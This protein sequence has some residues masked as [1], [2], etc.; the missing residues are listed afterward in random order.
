MF[1]KSNFTNKQIIIGSSYEFGSSKYNKKDIFIQLGNYF[2]KN[3]KNIPNIRIPNIGWDN[4]D[5]LH[6]DYGRIKFIYETIIEKLL[7]SNEFKS[8]QGF[9]H[10][11]K[12]ELEINIGIWLRSFIVFVYR[13]VKEFEG[14]KKEYICFVEGIE[15]ININ[16]KRPLNMHDYFFA[17]RRRNKLIDNC[18]IDILIILGLVKE[19]NINWKL[20]SESAIKVNEAFKIKKF[21]TLSLKYCKGILLDI[22]L[23]LSKKFFEPV[24]YIVCDIDIFRRIKFNLKKVNKL[25]YSLHNNSFSNSIYLN[26]LKDIRRNLK[27][28]SLTPLD[29]QTKL[30]LDEKVILIIEKLIPIYMPT[31]IYDGF[32]FTAKRAST[33]F[34]KNNPR[35]I[36]TSSNILKDAVF[37]IF[38]ILSKRRNSKFAIIQH[39]GGY[40]FSKINDEEEYQLN[41]SD[42]F[43]SWGWENSVID[44]FHIHNSKIIGK[45]G[46]FINFQEN[47]NNTKDQYKSDQKTRKIYIALNQWE[48]LDFRLFSFPSSDGILSKQMNLVNFL[49]NINLS[50]EKEVI[51]RGFTDSIFGLK[52]FFEKEI[53]PVEYR[54][55][56]KSSLIEDLS[57]DS[58]LFITDSNSTSWLQALDLNIPTILLIGKEFDDINHDKISIFNNSMKEHLIFN[59]PISTSKWINKNFHK[60]DGWWNSKNVQN[61]RLEI[62]DKYFKKN[63]DIN[64]FIEKF[65]NPNFL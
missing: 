5:T 2:K 30:S 31:S 62:L 64:R 32:Y 37:N 63:M 65:E 7:Y 53:G 23:I 50:K 54:D 17:F 48:K 59:D 60:I 46:S 55:R 47:T 20:N 42:Y 33:I 44:N 38:I 29:S 15:K 56:K 24:N 49:K 16:E 35:F 39:G 6:K 57:K 14:L 61:S 11:N 12:I 41:V 21:I 34:P 51:L 45:Y 19:E 18:K 43:F 27:E 25:I 9:E 1:N 22:L 13:T 36:I 28:L 40:G 26:K 10:K 8:I 58:Y 3:H 4:K 52:E